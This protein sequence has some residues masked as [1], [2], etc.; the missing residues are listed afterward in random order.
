M[1][2]VEKFTKKFLMENASTVWLG[3][4]DLQKWKAKCFQAVNSFK[5]KKDMTFRVHLL[6]ESFCIVFQKYIL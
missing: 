2:F 3:T 6:V 5:V 1:F 4:T